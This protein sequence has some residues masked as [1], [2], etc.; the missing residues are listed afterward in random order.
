MKLVDYMNEWWGDKHQEK[1]PFTY[2]MRYD[3]VHMC[4]KE[5][6]FIKWL[7]NNNKLKSDNDIEWIWISQ[8]WMFND[9]YRYSEK[10]IM[11][12]SISDNKLKDL[13]ELII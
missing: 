3:W 6:G 9:V 1:W 2:E 5:A 12:L 10:V 7:I 4:S 11:Y 13:L 8:W